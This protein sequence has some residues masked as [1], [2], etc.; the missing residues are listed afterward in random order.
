[1]IL[2]DE[3]IIKLCKEDKL[4]SPFLSVSEKIRGVSAGPT[5]HGYDVRVGDKYQ[6]PVGIK[7]VKPGVTKLTHHDYE[8]GVIDISSGITIT[9]KSC[10]HIETL[11]KFKM[12]FDVTAE[13]CNKST[14]DKLFLR[15]PN[16][17]IDAGFNG[18]I[19]LAIIN[20]GPWPVCIERGMGI[21]HIV[22]HRANKAKV[23]Y[24]GKYQNQQDPTGALF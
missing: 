11:E 3:Q 18:T 5:P 9:P 21:A 22:F 10:V 2:N 13:I 15:G 7:Y 12:P 23:P 1:M 20:M 14:W 4:M 19:T 8:G 6:V 16:T 24:N 17:R